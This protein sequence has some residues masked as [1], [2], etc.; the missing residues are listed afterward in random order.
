M[1]K[2]NKRGITHILIP[3]K[4]EYPMTLQ[5]KYREISVI[6]ERIEKK[7]GKDIQKWEQ[8]NERKELEDILLQWQKQHFRQAG[9][10]PLS[11]KEWKLKLVDES[12]QQAILNGNFE[13]QEELPEECQQILMFMK[14]N[15]KM[16]NK[17]NH[18]TTFEEFQGFIKRA[19][20]KS[21][22]SPSGRNY[23][24]YKTLLE[25][26][27]I[28]RIIHGIFDLALD[29][30]VVL[31]RW[32]QTVT[33]LMPKDDGPIYVH[34]LRAIHVVEAEL[35]FFSKIVY[36]KRMVNLAETNNEIT[37]EQYGGRKGRRAQSVVLNKLMYY[38][39]TYQ[40]REEAAFMDDDAKA[41]YDRIIPS[42]A[43]VEVQK[44]G[45]SPKAAALTRKIVEEQ[46]FRVKTA[47]GVSDNTYAYSLDDQTYGMGQGLG[48]S[49]A[50]WMV[51]SDTICKILAQEGA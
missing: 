31:N 33:T 13:M 51:T 28:L 2:N 44:W 34:R 6:W 3:A 43:S 15:A 17:I 8:I 25:N 1:K 48:W 37:D 35:Q 40:R 18:T 20:E 5:D 39:I 21:S 29:Y 50:I 10:T 26:N 23:S 30:N 49:G 42:L 27:R 4:E 38:G 22:C 41:C 12:T 24:H 32:A 9:E 36:A 14:T 47:H 16:R 7:N 46:Q 19:T 45:V 11:S